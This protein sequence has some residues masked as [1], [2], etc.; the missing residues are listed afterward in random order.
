MEAGKQSLPQAASL[1]ARAE[2]ALGIRLRFYGWVVISAAWLCMFVSS[3]ATM[4]FGFFIPEFR[5]DFGWSLSS[6][7]LARS[8]SAWVGAPLAPLVG[9][10]VEK[11][12]PRRVVLVGAVLGGV[13]VGL[14]GL[15]TQLW[16]LYLIM[17]VLTPLGMGM[18]YTLAPGSTVRRWFMR[19][20]GLAMS[21]FW[22]G[23]GLGMALGGP[24]VFWLISG[25]GWRWTFLALGLILFLGASLGGIFLRRDPESSG[26]YP[27]GIK[28]SEEELRAR[29]DFVA[30]ME[31]WSIR[32]ASRNLNFW[33][34]AVAQT[35]T[36]A[37]SI[38]LQTNLV[39][40]A[41]DEKG[42]ALS[43]EAATAIFSIYM[44]AAI[45]GR[46]FG[47][48]ASDLLMAWLK[49]SRKPMLYVSNLG[50]IASMLLALLVDD[51]LS[52]TLVM[53]F[54]GFSY[55]IGLTLFSTYLGD[56]FGVVNIPSLTGWT[57]LITAGVIALFPLAF[58][59][60]YDWTG[61]FDLAF[62][63]AAGYGLVCFICLA[64]VRP[65]QK[66]RPSLA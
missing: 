49:A 64:L 55:G 29:Q 2:R 41:T 28:P 14:T 38:S 12:G 21:L 19:R 52:L 22:T 65:P 47:G 62:V 7:I 18:T 6:I 35:G 34:F 27:D 42:L 30:R 10:W 60:I 40:W 3:V 24:I 31:R 43:R 48:V 37:I 57:M 53:L 45:A 9:S 5:D 13:A 50:M 61:S 8:I 44:F 4:N 23:S 51:R 11:F 46:V 59:A 56:L 25:Y 32:E 36:F 17:G 54:L 33:L 20:A 63:I 15:V 66:R 26:T 16:H 58:G 1:G 39:F